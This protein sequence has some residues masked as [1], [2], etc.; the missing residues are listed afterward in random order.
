MR[1]VKLCLP[2]LLT[3]ALLPCPPA[4]AAEQGTTHEYCGTN[5]P[6]DQ[7]TGFV[8]LPEGDVFCP[9]L[10]D[11]KAPHS[12]ISYVRGSSTSAFGTDLLSVGIADHFGMA[13][14]NGPRPGEGFQIGLEGAV[15]AQFDLLTQS[16]DLINAD[17][18]FGIPMTFRWRDLSAR[19][20]VYHQ[21]SHL[22]DEFVLR[23]R[24]PRE[25]FSFESTEGIL[26]YDAGPLRLY[27]GGEYLLHSQPQR[28]LSWQVHGGAE[29]R[30]REGALYRGKVTSVRLVAG[31]DVKAV[32]Y[33]EWEPQYSAIAG[34]E[35]SDTRPTMHAARH[36][37]VLGHYYYGPSPY[38]QFF[39]SDVT[40]YGVGVHFAL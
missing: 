18:I 34:F 36:W 8:A 37:S 32:Q 2:A 35:F 3:A 10:A 28:L 22:G 38:S 1:L 40:Y 15:F 11:P 6:P 21:S 17:Y 24:I 23:T 5:I 20:R 29:L 33:I 9:L 16:Y 4:R 13:R 19:V 27:G 30:Q 26:S 39:R 31:G 12:Y 14:W 25:N 7:A